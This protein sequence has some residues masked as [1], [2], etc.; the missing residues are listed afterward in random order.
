M[1]NVT[2]HPT[3][4]YEYDT[5]AVRDA[6]SKGIKIVRLFVELYVDGFGLWRKVQ[7]SPDGIYIMFGNDSR[8]DRNHLDNIHCLGMKPPNTDLHACLVPIV[9]DLKKL[10][11][12][13]D[14]YNTTL[15]IVPG[16]Q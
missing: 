10:Q 11:T 7:Y 12:T 9:D 14:W 16:S 5:R 15:K 8:A 6:E 2:P 13:T 1:K 3:N 4:A